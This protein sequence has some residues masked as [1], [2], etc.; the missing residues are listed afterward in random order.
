MDIYCRR[1]WQDHTS[2]TS[3][4]AVQAIE[5]SLEFALSPPLVDQIDEHKRRCR[6]N[7]DRWRQMFWG[8]AFVTHRGPG[9]SVFGAFPAAVL[10]RSPVTTSAD[11]L[12]F[13]AHCLYISGL[14]RDF[15]Y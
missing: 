1:I 5:T 7:A 2:A 4:R 6:G 11:D 15:Q 8:G 13:V 3:R 9:E 14:F 10:M 12:V